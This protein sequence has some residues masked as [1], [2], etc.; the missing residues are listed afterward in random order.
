MDTVR[1]A[2]A[3]QSLTNY[4]VR[5]VTDSLCSR[6]RQERVNAAWG[7]VKTLSGDI[8]LG[9]PGG[10]LP[11]AG[12]PFGRL[13]PAYV[14][15]EQAHGRS[16][17]RAAGDRDFRRAGLDPAWIGAVVSG[18]GVVANVVGGLLALGLIVY[19]FIALIKPEKF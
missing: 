18:T 10:T 4:I 12:S 17:L 5:V 8:R 11:P 13:C 9:A 6:P 7:R 1:V 19:L 15:R 2:E 16:G 14:R 3:G